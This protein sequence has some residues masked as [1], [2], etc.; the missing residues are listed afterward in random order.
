[1]NHV[2]NMFKSSG[3]GL[4]S[5]AR[6]LEVRPEKLMKEASADQ[7]L[8]NMMVIRIVFIILLLMM[9]MVILCIMMKKKR[10]SFL[11]TDLKACQQQSMFCN[12]NF[13]K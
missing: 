11:E 6:E 13:R 1:M 2:L 4:D 7:Y 12:L 3:D 5:F 10:K 8:L 9:L